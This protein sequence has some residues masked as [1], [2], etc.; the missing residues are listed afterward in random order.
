MSYAK[1]IIGNNKEKFQITKRKHMTFMTVFN[2]F[3]E[4]GPGKTNGVVVC[5]GVNFKI[6]VEI[7]FK[8]LLF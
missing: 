3:Q 8:N 4:T 1:I 6:I 2:S 7:V 5:F